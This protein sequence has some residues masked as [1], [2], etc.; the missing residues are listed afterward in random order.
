MQLSSPSR[1]GD[2]SGVEL[3]LIWGQIGVKQVQLG[4]FPQRAGLRLM[5]F[6]R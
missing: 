4:V 3:G 5:S 1:K 2:A 6:V